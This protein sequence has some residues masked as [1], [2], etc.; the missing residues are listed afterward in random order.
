M[1]ENFVEYCQFSVSDSL[2][3]G[4]VLEAKSTGVSMWQRHLLVITADCD[5]AHDKHNGRVTCVPLLRSDEYLLEFQIPRLRSRMGAKY[6]TA[7]QA[8]LKSTAASRISNKR[9]RAWATEEIPEEIVSALGLSGSNLQTA[10]ALLTSIRA[11]DEPATTLSDAVE[12]LVRAQLHSP[13]PPKRENAVKTVT[14]FLKSAYLQPPGDALFVSSIAPGLEGG[15]FAYLRH[16]QQVPQEAVA[17]GPTRSVIEH[18]RISRLADRYTL[19]LVQRFAL[20]FMS[21]GLPD[22]YEDMRNIHS[23][24]LGDFY[25]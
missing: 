5:L 25:R 10:L 18:R 3:Q 17:T 9:L 11:V 2:R 13:Q 23:E 19:A 22:D 12:A 6:V 4:D 24:L 7:L 20:V 14:E 21:I 16:L 15:F 8:I 1:H